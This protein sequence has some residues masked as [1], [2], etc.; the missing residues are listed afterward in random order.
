MSQVDSIFIFCDNKEY[1][2]QWTKDW[3][4]IKGVFIEI[5]PISFMT[6]NDDST[7]QIN[8]G[9]LDC[10]F[11]YTQILKDILLTINFGQ[12]HIQEFIEHCRE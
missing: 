6:T 10:S 3:T 2:E 7:N 11:M 9:Q 12:K 8:L 5:T 4:K 1:R